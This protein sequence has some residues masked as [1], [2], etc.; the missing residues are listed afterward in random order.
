MEATW[1]RLPSWDIK[2]TLARAP[3][4]CLQPFPPARWQPQCNVF[5][6]TQILSKVN[7]TL[8]RGPILSLKYLGQPLQ[9]AVL[10]LLYF[11]E[12]NHP[13]MF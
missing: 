6:A 3:Q 8:F 4:D 12:L 13:R 10:H 1:A 11:S 2:S 5:H 9:P 7:R